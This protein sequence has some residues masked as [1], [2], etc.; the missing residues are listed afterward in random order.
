M[1]KTLTVEIEAYSSHVLPCHLDRH[2]EELVEDIRE[3]VEGMQYDDFRRKVYIS[4]EEQEDIN[5]TV[6]VMKDD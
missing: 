3:R 1:R 4:W 5:L 2:L 6:K